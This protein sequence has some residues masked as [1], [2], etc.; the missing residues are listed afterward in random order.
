MRLLH[1]LCLGALLVASDARPT[2]TSDVAVRSPIDWWPWND[3]K[4]K[5]KP[6]PAITDADLK[7]KKLV[8]PTIRAWITNKGRT[9]VVG[10]R[11]ASTAKTCRDGS[12][13]PQKLKKGEVE[14]I[15]CKVK[16]DGQCVIPISLVSGGDLERQG[17]MTEGM[18]IGSGLRAS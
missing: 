10:R 13:N 12:T 6:K 11:C 16:N 1:V 8:D 4:P 2:V 15:L 18:P 14:Q 7:D 17:T 5:P 9:T 3:P